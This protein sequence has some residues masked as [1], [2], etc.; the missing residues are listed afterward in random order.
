MNLMDIMLSRKH[1]LHKTTYYLIS[2][3]KVQEQEKLIHGD[4]SQWLPLEGKDG[5]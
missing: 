2:L 4:R 1:N 5:D 3:N